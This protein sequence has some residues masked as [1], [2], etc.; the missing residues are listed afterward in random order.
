MLKTSGLLLAFATVML[1]L[2]VLIQPFLPEQYQVA[3]VCEKISASLISHPAT[4]ENSAALHSI[5]NTD[6]I[7]T[8][9]GHHR[10]IDSEVHNHP[11]HDTVQNT[12]SN[13][14]KNAFSAL[15]QNS[16]QL[17]QHHHHDG[18]HQCQYC[19]VYGHLMLPP[20]FQLEVI[21]LRTQLRLLAFA[22]QHQHL[23]FVLQ[24]L[25]LIP[26]GRAPPYL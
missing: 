26:Q 12:N 22:Q 5:N 3:P 16:Q 17:H 19:V 13:S 2:A 1:Q 7:N 20:D 10:S 9:H 18:N 11:N 25:Y 24:R 15:G 8:H 23:Y 21:V 6:H 14:N 4:K